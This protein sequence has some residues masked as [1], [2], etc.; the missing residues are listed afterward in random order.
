MR[1]VVAVLAAAGILFAAAAALA[2]DA[3]GEWTG[4]RKCV[5][6]AGKVGRLESCYGCWMKILQVPRTPTD[7]NQPV[8]LRIQI[9]ALPGIVWV[10]VD[11]GSSS[12]GQ[13]V[14]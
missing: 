4:K 14:T 11:V 6:H 12:G 13:V 2:F 10:G 5:Y 1:K 9:E 3:T 8:E 7:P